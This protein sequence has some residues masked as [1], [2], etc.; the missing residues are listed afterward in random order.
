[1]PLIGSKLENEV[2]LCVE[3]DSSFAIFDTYQNLAPCAREL[4]QQG[5]L[6]MQ[7][8]DFPGQYIFADWLIDP[9]T[10]V[11]GEVAAI[12]R[13]FQGLEYAVFAKPT[14][15]KGLTQ[16]TGEQRQGKTCFVSA[17]ASTAIPHLKE[18]V[19]YLSSQGFRV[20]LYTQHSNLFGNLENVEVVKPLERQ[21][22]WATCM[23]EA[24]FVI[25]NCGVT[26]LE[27]LSLKIPGL[28]IVTEANQ[29]AAGRALQ[30]VGVSVLL[31]DS[32]E[33][34]PVVSRALGI[35]EA[36]LSQVKLGW[37]L[38]AALS[39]FAHRALGAR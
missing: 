26:A 30:R 4:Q 36:G 5:T 35:S 39:E 3:C 25:T 7:L 28:S 22:F 29:V 2:S 21:A 19:S 34:E 18:T 1:M 13:I 10:T 12:E 38:E 24:D 6:T 32:R 37:K 16:S 23:E 14:A 33:I 15:D 9:F 8:I 11:S 31:E 17:G 20:R 27:R